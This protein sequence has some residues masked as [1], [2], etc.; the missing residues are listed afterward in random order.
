MGEKNWR[1]SVNAADH[2]NLYCITFYSL[3][4]SVFLILFYI[5]FFIF[6]IFNLIFVFF[7]KALLYINFRYLYILAFTLDFI[8]SSTMLYSLEVSLW[9]YCNRSVG[10]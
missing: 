2:Q 3:L 8:I 7:G 9:G 10:R 4:W 5:E 6:F 1:T